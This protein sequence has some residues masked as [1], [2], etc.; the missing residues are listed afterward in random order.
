MTHV[1]MG[2]LMLSLDVHWPF[3]FRMVWSW[4]SFISLDLAPFR[5]YAECSGAVDKSL[6]YFA[7]VT[8]YTYI[9]MYIYICI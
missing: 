3:S 4:L 7:E 2:A 5:A 8:C 9:S 6:L 1:Q